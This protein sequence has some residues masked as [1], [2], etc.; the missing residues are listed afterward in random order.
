MHSLDAGFPLIN[1][2]LML[3]AIGAVGGFL[4]GLLGVG[5]GSLFVPALVFAMAKLGMDPQHS[6]HIAV[7]TSLLIVLATSITSAR[8]HY[9]RGGVDLAL[10][11]DWTPYI[12]AGVAIG[13]F[14]ASSVDGAILKQVFAI[15]T[16]FICLYM[17]IGREKKAE[18]G[19]A[20]LSKHLQH[21]ICTI[22]GM[23]SSMIGVG[24]AIMTV[25]TMSYSGIPIQRAVGTGAALNI[26]IAFFGTA[27]YL[28]G[29]LKH[30]EGMPP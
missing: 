11:R 1:I 2:I 14:F 26:A 29:G 28:I 18:P 5:G 27:G 19:V 25:P 30:T 8:A 3:L 7:A 24:G 16:L 12:I 4:S 20:L 10:C 17:A 13:T 15:V 6:M 21:I 9:H 22:T 23:L